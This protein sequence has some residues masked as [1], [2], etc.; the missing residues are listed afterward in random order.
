M[1]YQS[2]NP[3][4]GKLLKSFEHLSAV[5]LKDSLASAQDCY[6]T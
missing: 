2:V 4:G 3:N 1:T 6:Q 5:Q